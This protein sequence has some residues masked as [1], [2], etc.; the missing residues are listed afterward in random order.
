MGIPSGVARIS[1]VGHQTGGEIFD[2]SFWVGGTGVPTSN[3][4]ANTYAA[5]VSS[6][7]GGPTLTELCSLLDSDSGYDE[8][9]VYSYPS[10]GPTASFVGSATIG[11]GTGTNSTFMPLQQCMCITLLTGL[12]GRQNRGRMYLPATGL[13][14]TS[15]H[16]FS[17]TTVQNVV[18]AMAGFFGG[19]NGL[20]STNDV[21]VVSQTATTFHTVTAVRADERPDIQRRRANR[22]ATG[23]SHLATI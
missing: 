16:L 15:G 1:L 7:L 19:V 17:G 23:A 21:C 9:R 20:G 13:S 10:G 11:S 8:V 5:Q 6:Q 12:S 14:L 4:D 3:A 22:Q 2:T 18:E